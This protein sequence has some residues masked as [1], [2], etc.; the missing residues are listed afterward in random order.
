M[1]GNKLNTGKNHSLPHFTKE[2]GALKDL[3]KTKDLNISKE[4]QDS[5]DLLSKI[6]NFNSLVGKGILLCLQKQASLAQT[7]FDVLQECG[8][9]KD[10]L[11]MSGQDK[12]LRPNKGSFS[13]VVS[14]RHESGN[15]SSLAKL[16]GFIDEMG[17]LLGNF[18]HEKEEKKIKPLEIEISLLASPS[19]HL[20]KSKDSQR[21]PKPSFSN[22][23][24]DVKR[25]SMPLVNISSAGENYSMTT[26]RKAESSL[27]F[28]NDQRVLTENMQIINSNRAIQ[29][30]TQNKILPKKTQVK[31]EIKTKSQA[32]KLN[33]KNITSQTFA[34]SKS[35]ATSAKVVNNNKEATD[36][37]Y[38]PHIIK[39]LQQQKEK[40]NNNPLK[41]MRS[42]ARDYSSFDMISPKPVT[43]T[44]PKKE[45]F[46]ESVLEHQDERDDSLNSS[47]NLVSTPAI[48]TDRMFRTLDA[49]E[50]SLLQSLNN[51]KTSTIP[52]KEKRTLK[53][54]LQEEY[55]AKGNEF[56]RSDLG[57]LYEKKYIISAKWWRSWK[58]YVNFDSLDDSTSIFLISEY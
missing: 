16:Q 12:F 44:I 14:P 35:K 39:E 43:S 51:L 38:P 1:K 26:R 30:Q 10:K 47:E 5:A 37:F 32:L 52:L 15:L 42:T 50:N 56:P 28:V 48:D 31:S 58:E 29:S 54:L 24:N 45:L 17:L 55:G 8:I 2:M 40:E 7:L 23:S 25:S 27:N 53:R 34:E 41:S 13:G 36:F 19:E 49:H 57:Q 20:N 18:S 3:N 11:R 9:P 4:E 21:S 6:C 46:D 22:R 33:L